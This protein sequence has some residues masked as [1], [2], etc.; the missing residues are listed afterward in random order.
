[1]IKY[2]IYQKFRN[3]NGNTFSFNP[4]VFYFSY[5]PW[6][7]AS[8][9]GSLTTL[10]GGLGEEIATRISTSL[11]HYVTV[12]SLSSCRCSKHSV[13]R[14]L[15]LNWSEHFIWCGCFQICSG[16]NNTSSL[17]LY[18]CKVIHLINKGVTSPYV[19]E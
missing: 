6:L 12:P 1:M 3:S 19:Q 14:L 5:L 18:A 13:S 17:L 9:G 11:S 8:E 15:T 2:T 7:A 10:Q 4:N 16:N